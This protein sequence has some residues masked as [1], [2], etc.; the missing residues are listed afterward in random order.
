MTPPDTPEERDIE[1]LL[2]NDR[3]NLPSFVKN[4]NRGVGFD[5][6]DE[7]LKAWWLNRY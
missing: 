5:D 2:R 1:V 6:L 3:E 4:L 7:D